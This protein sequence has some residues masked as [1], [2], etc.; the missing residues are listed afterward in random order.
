MDWFKNMFSGGKNPESGSAPEGAENFQMQKTISDKAEKNVDSKTENEVKKKEEY[1]RETVNGTELVTSKSFSNLMRVAKDPELKDADYYIDKT[2][3]TM[4]MYVRGSN[5]P[6]EIVSAVELNGNY[7]KRPTLKICFDAGHVTS[8]TPLQVFQQGISRVPRIM[9]YSKGQDGSEKF[10]IMFFEKDKNGN[11][12]VEGLTSIE[13]EPSSDKGFTYSL[14]MSSYGLEKI[15]RLLGKFDQ[16]AIVSSDE[17][18]LF[19][20][21]PLIDEI[22]VQIKKED[23]KR[24]SVSIQDLVKGMAI[25]ERNGLRVTVVTENKDGSITVKKKDYSDEY[26][27]SLKILHEE[28]HAANQE[29]DKKRYEKAKTDKYMSSLGLGLLSKDYTIFDRKD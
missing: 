9:S 8:D 24:V 27:Q 15:Q 3:E 6:K 29:T 10:D 5:D 17:V 22:A 20:K 14:D 23:A 19:V 7:K 16:N 11:Q 13:K 18:N 25:G 4:E 12:V 26:L 1:T 28:F 21:L 2:T